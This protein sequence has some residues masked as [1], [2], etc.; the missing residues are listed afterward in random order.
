[1]L[2]LNINIFGL[3]RVPVATKTFESLYGGQ[4]TLST[5]LIK[6]NYLPEIILKPVAIYFSSDF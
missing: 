3:K 1:M 4:L 6:P 2:L 5:Q